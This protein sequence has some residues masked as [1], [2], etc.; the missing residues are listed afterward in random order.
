[1]TTY[2]KNGGSWTVSSDIYIKDA[3]VWKLAKEIYVRDAGVWKRGHLRILD[4]NI[5]AN[6]AEYNVYSAAIAAGWNG[7]DKLTANVII[8]TGNYVY[9]SSTSKY[10]I[11]TGPSAL[12]PSGSDIR[13][14][15]N[16]IIAAQGGTGGHGGNASSGTAR[17][18]AVG[19][20]GGNALRLDITTS[21]ANYG[22]IASGGGG[23]G[24]GGGNRNNTPER[25]RG[26]GGGG[27]GRTGLTNSPGGPGGDATSAAQFVY[28]DKD[29]WL[30]AWHL[31]GSEY[32]IPKRNPA[33]RHPAICQHDP[34][35]E[36]VFQHCCN[37][38]DDLAAGR[39]I[40]GIVSRRFAP[41]A[42][43]SFAEKRRRVREKKAF[44]IPPPSGIVK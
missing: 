32:G 6:T 41:D 35:G 31:A 19:F 5:S 7:T 17:S 4:L 43:A 33:Y 12:W 24:G 18:G 16:G 10:A 14:Y 13:I 40:A 22:T 30:L 44:V 8:S 25:A 38:K 27:G 20:N 9:S 1:M 15:N 26:G 34:A 2:V 36:L 21:I 23:G 42:A 28:G 11:D 29:C 3:S 37:G 39:V